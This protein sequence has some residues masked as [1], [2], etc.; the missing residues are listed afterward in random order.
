M[1]GTHRSPRALSLRA[2]P[3]VAVSLAAALSACGKPATANVLRGVAPAK[4]VSQA[5]AGL[6]GG[7]YRILGTQTIEVDGSGMSSAAT[8]GRPAVIDVRQTLAGEVQSPQRFSGT[9]TTDQHTPVRFV[10][11]DGTAY[12]SRDGTT[13][14]EAPFLS[15]LYVQIGVAHLQDALKQI[16]SVR[17][18]GPVRVDGVDAE[19][20]AATMSSAYI[21]DIGRQVATSMSASAGIP[22]D[23]VAKAMSAISVD[24]LGITFDVARVTGRLVSSDSSG[25]MSMDLEKMA[26]AIG[27]PLPA[28]VGGVMRI[29]VDAVQKL[30]DHGPHITIPRPVS[31]GTMTLQEFASLLNSGATG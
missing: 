2:A 23:L 15:R 21:L 13:W 3:L 22:A 14:M 10:F 26:A 29:R 1:A 16:T 17:D 7:G 30:S 9:L 11:Y 24:R 28:G 4:V 12:V 5:V 25:Q 27:K 19:S 6:G 18:T 31:S 8:G 20:Y